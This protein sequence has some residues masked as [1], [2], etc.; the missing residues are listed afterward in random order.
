MDGH[1]EIDESLSRLIVY[2]QRAL[3]GADQFAVRRDV[4]V[5][6]P[7]DA[8]VAAGFDLGEFFMNRFAGFGP[9][10]PEI[11]AVDVPVGEPE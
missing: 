11:N 4:L 2:A 3:V 8:H 6:R 10:A 1:V 9:L 7:D 5:F